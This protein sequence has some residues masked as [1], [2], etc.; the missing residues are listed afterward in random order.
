MIG[1]FWRAILDRVWLKI[2]ADALIGIV[3]KSGSGKTILTRLLQGL[4]PVQEG[5]IRFDGISR[6]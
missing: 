5:V 2:P 1:P 4:Y 3:G 6:D